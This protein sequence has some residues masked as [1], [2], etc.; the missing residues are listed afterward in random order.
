M[1]P[2]LI[3]VRTIRMSETRP[4]DAVTA[5]LVRT[6]LGTLAMFL[7][8]LV[9]GAVAAFAPVLPALNGRDFRL[10][11]VIMAASMCAVA[12]VLHSRLRWP[13]ID[14]LASLVG[15][16]AV[17]LCVIGLFSG[18]T[19]LHLIDPFNLWWLGAVSLYIVPPWLA[20]LVIGG[21]VRK[22]HSGHGA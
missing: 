11:G 9:A 2:R 6:S 10:P 17:A 22:H 13:S 18:L 20:G 21:L 1:H 7:C 14:L 19:G 8:A 4:G 3:L 12:V 5:H 15:A 16:E